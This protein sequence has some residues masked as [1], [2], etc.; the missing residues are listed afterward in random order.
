MS[1]WRQ[2]RVALNRLMERG[3]VEKKHLLAASKAAK[4]KRAH[5]Q[6][7]RTGAD[8]TPD[9]GALARTTVYEWLN[10]D[11]DSAVSDDWEKTRNL[12]RCIEE[13]ARR[14]DKPVFIDYAK[15]CGAWERLRDAKWRL[16]R[17]DLHLTS[18]N[19]IGGSDG[20]GDA[21]LFHLSAR[22]FTEWFP[23]QELPG[24]IARRRKTAAASRASD[25]EAAR[26]AAVD[27]VTKATQNFGETD[28]RTLAARHGLAF[29]T[30]QSGQ[31]PRA[32][33]LTSDL[34]GDCGEHLG[35][36]HVLSRLA[37]LRQAW[38]TGHMGQW[39][40]ANRLYAEA[41]RAE[42]AQPDHD[43]ALWLLARWGM[44]RTGGRS[45]N[46]IHAHAELE[47][48]LPRMNETLGPDHPAALAAGCAHARAVG[49][50]G[51]P[52]AAH[53]L[54]K[55]LHDRAVVALGSEH[56]STLRIGIALA[57]WALYSGATDEAFSLACEAREDCAVLLGLDDPVSINAA[58]TEALC[59]FERGEKE[60]A[61]EA[62]ADIRG[63]R[64]RVLGPEHPDTLQ[65]ASNHA[66]VLS[67]VEG[68]ALA[69]ERF[70]ELY[71]Q[72]GRVLGREHPETL[73]IQ[74]NLAL[75]TM[76]ATGPGTARR[77]C[78]AAF[79]SLRRVLGSE[80]PDT[81]WAQ[82]LHTDIESRYSSAVGHGA[83]TRSS[84]GYHT[85]SG[86][87][88]GE[89][90][91]SDRALKCAITPVRWSSRP[92]A[93]RDPLPPEGTVTPPSH[94]VDGFAVL[95]AVASMP[96][97]TWSYR[98]EEHVRHIGPMAQDWQAALGVGADDRT[99]QSV[100]ANGVSV[101]AVQALLRLVESLQAEVRELRGRLDGLEHPDRSDPR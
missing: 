34:R 47:E 3:G 72:M 26:R 78:F 93:E 31:F 6:R 62:L 66:V 85:F 58:E 7:G 89:G 28:P 94:E 65:T 21:V 54:F 4:A 13:L 36:H 14:R 37:V 22:E 32:L 11:S 69:V 41:L 24:V 33:E 8:G 79:D 53:R 25:I 50:A 55:E 35:A 82:N 61:L 81:V 23:G 83:A 68:P 90:S 87:G 16:S 84:T 70:T 49:V 74:V 59:R 64:E 44:A 15:A 17:F 27:L 51:D 42:A 5:G 18:D 2:Y 9:F 43:E 95:R 1:T 57:C 77:L 71:E 76:S 12:L 88:G 98:G 75:A 63:R 101:V 48:L 45:G 52:D 92:G 19:W 60:A 40:E 99:I 56:H 67:A 97:S 20:V 80:H 73:R 38:W 46:W 91:A 30:G 29:W 86:G 39:R 10:Q 96:V 100:D